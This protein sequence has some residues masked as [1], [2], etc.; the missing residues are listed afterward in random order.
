MKYYIYSFF[1]LFSY[2]NTFGQLTK[3]QLLTIDS[4][5][6]SI[7]S[8]AHDT[9]KIAAYNAWDNIIYISDPKLDQELNQEI[10]AIAEKNLKNHNL[11]AKEKHTFKKSLALALNSLGIIFYNKGENMQALDF[12]SRSLKLREAIADKKGIAATLNNLGIVYQDQAENVKAIDCYTHSRTIN[13][14]IGDKNGEANCLSNIGR[15]YYELGDID[16]A[17]DYLLKSLKIRE[18]IGDKRGMAIAY[19]NIG[20]IYQGEKNSEKALEY[21]RQYLKISEELGDKNKIALALGNIGTVYE[22]K[23][24]NGKA[25]EYFGQALLIFKETGNK[26][27]ESAILSQMGNISLKNN[28][29]PK[30]KK[31]YEEALC[32]GQNAGLVQS[33]KDASKALYTI[34]KTTGDYSNALKM[35]ELYITMRDSISNENNQKEILKR[36]LKYSY[37]KQ[38]ALDEKEHEKEVR[39]SVE[40]EKSQKII[41]YSI[42]C[43]LVIVSVL[44]FFLFKRV[45]ITKKQKNIIEK[46][47]VQILEGINYSKKIQE[48]LLPPIEKMSETVSNIYIFNEPKDIVS[49]DFYFHKEIDNYTLFICADCTGH[50]VPGGFMCTLGSLLLD[51]ITSE[52]ILQ[53]SEILEKLNGEIIRTLHQHKGGEIQDG[54]DLSVCLIDR[55]DCK[56]QFSGA[57]N[58]IIVVESE[59]AKRYKADPIPVGGN[60]TKNGKPLERSFNTHSIPIG[61]ND[62]LYMYTDG[63]MEQSGGTEG[64]PMSYTQ[65]ENILVKLSKKQKT[66]EKDMFLK[67]ELHSWRSTREKDDDILIIGLQLVV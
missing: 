19:N 20:T 52:G 47:N 58:G 12:Y 50:G 38:K 42:A 26:K 61:K 33:V 7:S 5:K 39:L 3:L 29:K 8:A 56:I 62:W 45:Q 4:L 49:G 44:S 15:I 25:L 63:Y 66:E 1:F 59:G 54:M 55:Q 32:I 34:F 17:F 30:A 41:S 60:Y 46:Q 65:F 18:A 16:K 43:C 10:V 36:E 22:K 6:Q 48:S 35:H 53:P 14:A 11:S 28:D 2:L 23:D 40:S 27:W 31:F 9:N 21:F 13:E 67:D 64:I 57:R 37:E 51:K 24:D